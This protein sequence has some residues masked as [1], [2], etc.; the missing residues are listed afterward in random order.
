[1]DRVTYPNEDVQE[2]LQEHFIGVKLEQHIDAKSVAQLLRPRKLTWSPLFLVLGPSGIEHRLILGYYPPREF[3]AELRDFSAIGPTDTERERFLQMAKTVGDT[4][5]ASVTRGLLFE[6]ATR[7]LLDHEHIDLDQVIA[8]YEAAEA[9]DLAAAVDV[10][11][12]DAL[13]VPGDG[14]DLGPR[15]LFS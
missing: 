6:K 7:E 13:V 14:V 12:K 2:Y 1:M 3:M 9:R 4:D 10:A 8:E 11:F 5:P 15:L